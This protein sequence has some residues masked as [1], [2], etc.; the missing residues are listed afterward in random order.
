[1]KIYHII[2]NSSHYYWK[3]NL[4][5]SL[6]VALCAAVITGALIVGDSVR[7]SLE[8]T[9]R[10]RLGTT[11][12]SIT[13]GETFFTQNLATKLNNDENIAASAVVKLQGSATSQG[14]KLRLNKVQFIGID[15]NFNKASS[16]DYFD[17]IPAGE[18][19]VSQ[20]VA[21]RLNLEVGNFLLLKIE[22]AG[23]MPK[24]T[25][26][27]SDENQYVSRRVKINKIADKEHLGRFGLLNSQTAPFNIFVPVD[28]LNKLM[29]MDARANLILINSEKRKEEIALKLQ[30]SI[31]MKDLGLI[32]KQHPQKN[33]WAISSDK[34]FIKDNVAD[35]IREIFPDS[36]QVLTYFANSIKSKK[37]SSPYS[38]VSTLNN[39]YVR[40]DE[41]VINSWLAED[42][43]VKTGDTLSMDYF[44]IGLLRELEEHS[45]NFI[46][47]RV[48]PIE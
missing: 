10:Y 26:F 35:K 32:L 22:K 30:K 15:K 17:S 23:L 21:L 9:A 3:R 20:N 1:M 12:Y 24:N 38:F 14:S 18:V 33:Y 11:D 46:V 25:P 43:Q 44:S 31:R 4:Y 2:F 6:A 19:I 27:V 37:N 40:E 45:E 29:E 48:I 5:V 13:A 36:R 47:R 16:S 42:L 41:I 8:Q 34:V 39:D 7:Y 28:W